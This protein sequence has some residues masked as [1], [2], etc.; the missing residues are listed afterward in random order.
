MPID[1]DPAPAFIITPAR[2]VKI[3]RYKRWLERHAPEWDEEAEL[4][5]CASE[6]PA[7]ETPE[8]S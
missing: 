5:P 6:Q 4:L 3:D 2:Q 1:Y 8:G 7:G